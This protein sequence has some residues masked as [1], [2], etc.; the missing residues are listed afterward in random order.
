MVLRIFGNSYR[1]LYRKIDR[2][3]KESKERERERERERNIE[4]DKNLD[5]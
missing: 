4:K 5:L 3:E 1:R 2:G